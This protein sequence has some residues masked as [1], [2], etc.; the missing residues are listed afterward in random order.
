MKSTRQ[1]RIGDTVYIPGE[2]NSKEHELIPLEGYAPAK[3]TLFASVFPIDPAQLDAMYAA[4]DRLLLNDS[5]ISIIRDQSPL[6]GSGLR[7]G[8]LGFLHMEVF[9]Q[10]LQDEFDMNVIMTT[11]SVPYQIRY[12]DGSEKIVS[13]TSEWPEPGKNVKYEVFEPVVLVIIYLSNYFVIFT[14]VISMHF[15]HSRVHVRLPS[16]HRKIITVP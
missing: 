12:S 3:Q 7:C 9:N 5:S 10:R 13:C 6:L 4:V 16:L 8:F 15:T 11:P 2:W 14:L 1:A